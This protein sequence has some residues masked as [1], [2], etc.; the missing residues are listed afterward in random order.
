MVRFEE[1]RSLKCFQPTS[2]FY[3]DLVSSNT[4]ENIHKNVRIGLALHQEFPIISS[5]LA[6]TQTNIGAGIRNNIKKVYS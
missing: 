5:P 4:A 1:C 2:C 6:R 3:C